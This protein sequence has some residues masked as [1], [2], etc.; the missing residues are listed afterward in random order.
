M[1]HWAHGDWECR[2]ASG[3]GACVPE[4]VLDGMEVHSRPRL[5]NEKLPIRERCRLGACAVANG[6]GAVVSITPSPGRGG[7]LHVVM[8]SQGAGHGMLRDQYV[9]EQWQN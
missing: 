5:P 8:F 7:R 6:G 4:D 2:L 3:E 1:G 9:P